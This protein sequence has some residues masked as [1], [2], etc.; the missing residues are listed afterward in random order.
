[1]IIRTAVSAVAALIFTA[2]MALAAPTPTPKPMPSPTLNPQ[3]QG[4]EVAFV[5]GIQKDLMARFPTAADAIKA[6]YFRYGNEDSDGAISYANLQ[7]QSADPQHP[8]QLWYDV[9]GNLLGADFSVLQSNS[10][11]PPKLWGVD[12]QRW[13]SFREHIHY[14]LAGPNGTETY[15][16]MSAKKFVAAGG[17]ATDPGAAAL[18]AALAKAGKPPI[19]V[20]QVKRVFL[21]PS[22]WDLIVW[23]KPNPNGAFADKNPTVTPS[24]TAEKDDM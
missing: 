10:I 15:G 22:I 4:T 8:S 23:V 19:T 24:A 17:S 12:Y 14:V 21:F 7:W 18:V 6:G 20:A 3:P 16:G 5:D 9:K 11:E 1:M 2:G 13:T